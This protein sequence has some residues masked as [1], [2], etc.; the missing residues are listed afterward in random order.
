MAFINITTLIDRILY[1]FE[2]L[3]VLLL[4]PVNNEYIENLVRFPIYYGYVCDERGWVEIREFT[5]YKNRPE[6]LAQLEEFI[7]SLETDFWVRVSHR[8][9]YPHLSREIVNYRPFL[10][11][12]FLE[13]AVLAMQYKV[14]GGSIKDNSGNDITGDQIFDAIFRMPALWFYNAGTPKMQKEL[15]EI[16][17]DV[18]GV[19]AGYLRDNNV[20]FEN[21][22]LRGVAF[23][24]YDDLYTLKF[25]HLPKIMS[26]LSKYIPI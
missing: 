2:Y 23:D 3:L 14:W 19:D 13:V 8:G 24:V 6:M 21:A 15:R 16:Y 9:D 18:M 7:K 12:S 17:R 4:Y 10:H 1:P 11:H 20:M 25:K 26:K 22:G 5:C